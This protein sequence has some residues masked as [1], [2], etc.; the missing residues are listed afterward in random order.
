MR[1]GVLGYWR[2]AIFLAIVALFACVL[3]PAN[4]ANAAINSQINF[5]GKLTNT[6][7][8]NVTNGTYSI[9]FSIYTVASGGSNIWTETQGSVSVTDG[10]FRVALGSGTALPGSVDFNSSSLYLGIK[11]G[12]DPEMSPRVQFTAAP[13]AFNSDKL[14]GIASTGFAQLGLAAAQSES[15]TNAL[16]FLNKTSTGN[17]LQLQQ[18]AADKFVVS[19]AGL[20]TTAS[21]NSASIVDGT[22]ANGDLVNS[23]VTVVAGSG[24]VTGGAVS[25]GGSVT[26]DIGAGNG[27]TVNANDI[28]VRALTSAD[29][30]SA[31]TSSG[32]GIEVL[33]S[34]AGLLQG[35]SDGQVLKWNETTD[36]WACNSAFTS[37]SLN[38]SDFAD[39]LTVDAATTIS[40]GAN[41]L[42]TN[43]SGTGDYAI[44]FGGNTVFQILD[45]GAVTIGSILADQTIGLD[46]GTGA[47]NIAT[48]SDANA[49]NIGT[50]TAADT[51]T[52]G[53]A[54]ASVA[55][56]DAQ[57]SVTS[58]GAA[59]FASLAGAGL[60]DCDQ[61]D[62]VLKW[63][64]TTSQFSCGTNRGTSHTRLSGLYTNNTAGFT[65]V[66]DDT[67][68]LSDIGFAVGASETWVFE[69]VLY[70]D[71]PIAA[72]HRL[73]VTAPTGATCVVGFENTEDGVSVGN[74][75]CGTS[76]GTLNAATTAN[77]VLKVNGSVV[78]AATTGTVMVQYSQAVAS[79]TSNIRA[80]SF[81]TAYRISG[82]DYAE[83]YF[84]KNG[85]I[86]PGTIVA[87]DGSGVSQVGSASKPYS[88]QQI[89]IVSTN[90]GHVIGD[91]DGVG[92]PVAVALSGRVPIK[93]STEN[94]LPKAGEMITVS[95]SKPG[96]GMTSNQSGYIV[97]QMMMDATDNEDGTASGY[98]Y[99]RHGYWQAPL[100]VNLDDVLGSNDVVSFGSAIREGDISDDLE[101]NTALSG[102]FSSLD[103]STVNEIMRGFTI[104]QAQ[105]GSLSERVTK[106][107]QLGLLSLE[108]F[109]EFF[110]ETD[111]VL[112]FL[113]GVN[114]DGNVFFGG[115]VRFN[116]NSV[117]TVIIPKGDVKKEIMF[118]P[119]LSTTPIVSLSPNDFLEGSWRVTNATTESFVIEL[120]APQKN[121]VQF[122]WQAVLTE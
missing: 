66:D 78:T 89:G 90:P 69:A 44:Q 31:T 61:S 4:S 55:I 74:T 35:C 45:T 9:V 65:D 85:G 39:A 103:P 94:G 81:I 6:D 46:N 2:S 33:A 114:F 80:G 27:I 109:S 7:G 102:S 79:G 36:V 37:N 48:D 1:Q 117:G 84:S 83:L 14:G 108:S 21:V 24:L 3:L 113:G 122:T 112:T 8:T 16:I 25:L 67:T 10:I 76:S 30:L 15:S 53:D 86:Q 101:L 60:S 93:L 72:D 43:L 5:Q 42:T 70:A 111:G 118:D 50:G 19:N 120:A 63:D 32:S 28:A 121:D 100:S 29:G 22:V 105:I 23:G 57:W 58:A 71:A 88:D 34:G 54:N 18:G 96:Y 77:D 56:A 97:G 52:I 98:V 26:V 106:L 38:F 107:E 110:K 62:D 115:E 87:L 13:Y 64:S 41:N 49:V 95:G 11:V 47:I 12:A 82:A 119:H 92:A 99:V 116:K 17:L 51:V 73:Q 68:G 104:Q 59:S 20:L 40:L 91:A 75:G